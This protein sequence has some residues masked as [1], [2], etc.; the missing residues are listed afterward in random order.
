MATEVVTTLSES[1][2]ALAQQKANEIASSIT[3]PVVQDNQFVFFAAFDGTNNNRED[4]SYSGDPQSTNV[5]EL[6]DQFFAARQQNQNFGGNYYPGP[7]T[8]G[9]LTASSWLPPQVTQQVINTATQAYNDFARQASEWL[10]TNPGGSVTT[11]VTAFSR[12]SASA[13]I[14]SQILFEK[15]LVDPRKKKRGSELNF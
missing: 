12:G 2:I 3:T 9:T 6:Y 1:A 15:G 10:D 13:A 14:F 8:E 4:L 7:G 5:G 11:M